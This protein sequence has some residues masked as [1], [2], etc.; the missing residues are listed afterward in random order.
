MFS[1]A[2]PASART[3]TMAGRSFKAFCTISTGVG[4][5]Y[6]RVSTISNSPFAAICGTDSRIFPV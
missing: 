1:T 3:S 5:M 2:A 6:P 4:Q